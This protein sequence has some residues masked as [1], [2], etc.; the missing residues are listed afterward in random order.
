MKTKKLLSLVVI[1]LMSISLSASVEHLS[2]T[3]VQNGAYF[4]YCTTVDSV[5]VH[6]P[7]GAGA[8]WWYNQ[9][10][11]DVFNDSIIITHDL[12]GVWYWNGS[13]NFTV[14]FVSIAPTE[15]FASEELYKCPETSMVILGQ[16]EHQPDFTYLWGAGE[17]TQSL[18][19]LIPGNVFV[20]VTG[21]CGE[22]TD[23]MEV[24]NWPSP[25]PELGENVTTC[26][27]ST[28]TLNPGTFAGYL[29]NTGA[30]SPTLD[31]TVG[32]TYS[33]EVTDDNGC[34][35]EDEIEVE[36]V[37]APAIEICFVEF[38]TITHKNRIVWAAAPENADDINVYSEIATDV[39]SLIG[40]VP[41][42]QTSYIDMNSNPQNM[43]YS[44][45]IAIND[46]CDNEGSQ[47]AFHKTITLLSAYDQP[48]NTYG[49][50]WSAYI[51]I[52]VANYLIYGITAN[53]T[54][55][56]I[57]SVPG[58]TYFYNYSNPSPTFV[59]YFVGFYT[60]DCGAKSDYMVKSNLVNS[61]SSS[62]VNQS[63]FANISIYPNPATSQINIITDQ[64][65]N[66]ITIYSI[67]GQEMLKLN[68][69]K[70]VDVSGLAAG[71][72]SVKIVTD[73]GVAV[74]RVVVE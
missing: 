55:I 5:I 1:L 14:N 6:K 42:S 34:K 68:N 35:T 38:D 66:E 65:I 20:T 23:Y 47:S 24:L 31:V 16:A 51:G 39:Y 43:S 62:F 2:M 52:S 61:N 18:Q 8:P 49:F 33:V 22:V 9:E 21:A 37:F 26:N 32:N 48:T 45:K 72:Y 7:E 58:N 3:G 29:W 44:Y 4:Y 25:D 15:P 53:N 13:I 10:E 69:T 63:Q 57:A 67:T 56:Q 73:S 74:E 28:V 41:A 19:L 70:T 71:S 60:D 12:A 11:G 64:T 40:S 54:V 30:I 36:F 50:T 46:T 59:K 17:T 27:G